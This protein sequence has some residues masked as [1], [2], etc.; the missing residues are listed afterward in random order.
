MNTT[1]FLNQ[2]PIKL[3]A[4]Q[5]IQSGGEGMVFRWQD[6][7]VKLY[8]HPTPQHQ[9]KLAYLLGSGLVQ[10]FPTAVFAPCAPVTD[11][12]GSLIGF[13]MPLLPPGS[14]PLKALSNPLFRQ[15]NNIPLPTIIALLAKIHATLTHLHQHHIII[16]DLNDT[17]IF[18]TPASPPPSPGHPGVP[19]GLTP[20]LIDTDSYQ[21][22][23]FPCPVA[24]SAF[25][26]PDL[27]GVADLGARPYFTPRT[28][29]YAFAVLLVKSLLGVHP[30]GGAHPQ[31]KTVMA[32][33]QARLSIWQPA[34]TRP[35]NSLPLDTLSDECQHF[36]QRIFEHGERPSFPAT[37]LT[38]AL[39]TAVPKHLPTHQPAPAGSWRTLLANEGFIEHLALLPN[40]RIVVILHTG[41]SYKLVRLG[42]GG[43]W[44]EMA[45]FDGS[46]GYQF[47]HFGGQFLAVNPPQRPHL[48][49]L[50][51]GGSAPQKVGLIETAVFRDTAVFAAT[52]QHLYRIAGNWI[53]RGQVQNGQYVED[54]IATAHKQ[55]TWFQASPYNDAIA[56]Y[57]RVFAEYRFFVQT[58]AGS[59]DLILP[60]LLVGEHI[61]RAG[62]AFGADTVA[63]IVQLA[64][65]GAMHTVTHV[66]SFNGRYQH[67]QDDA[68][69]V[70]ETAPSS[71]FRTGV[72]TYP[73]TPLPAD[74]TPPAR[75]LRLG[76]HLLMQE[77]TRCSVTPFQ[78]SPL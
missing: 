23:N 36:L 21:F 18:F 50:D 8:H 76:R 35:A 48:L 25:L 56:G 66:F 30:Y 62:V 4:A 58:G 46:A 72:N 52:P 38:N 10:Q 74:Y 1:I 67:S 77:P 45:L 44:E 49:L 3:D 12:N 47:A 59:Y 26:D 39:R 65:G 40:G 55:Q 33:A 24:M 17:N 7:A 68:N 5:L 57:H 51:V 53:M 75:L 20:S 27:Y 78:T 9:A 60:P 73:I 31:H 2:Q 61:A 6:T 71:A 34:V 37:L 54:A 63:V 43:K 29:W 11:S 13:Q 41:Q 22:A 15:K 42:I 70:W 16:G 28:D 19:A 64:G 69:D 14:Q 32:R